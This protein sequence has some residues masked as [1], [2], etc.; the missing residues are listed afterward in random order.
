[1]EKQKQR[2]GFLKDSF[3]SRINSRVEVEVTPP[4]MFT[5]VPKLPQNLELSG[6]KVPNLNDHK[7]HCIGLVLLHLI[8]TKSL[9]AS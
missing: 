1:L 9:M 5:G 8:N 3:N 2:I 6:F 4:Y 7:L